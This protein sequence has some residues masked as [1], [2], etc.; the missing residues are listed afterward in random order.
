[1]MEPNAL[2]IETSTNVESLLPVSS[3]IHAQE[4]VELVNR[5]EPAMKDA[6]MYWSMIHYK[7]VKFDLLP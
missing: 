2:L 4:N 7:G 3:M 5:S 6:M 1:M